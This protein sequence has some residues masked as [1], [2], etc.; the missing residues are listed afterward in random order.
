MIHSLIIN[1]TG[2]GASQSVSGLTDLVIYLLLFPFGRIGPCAVRGLDTPVVQDVF[3]EKRDE[4]SLYLSFKIK[5]P[6]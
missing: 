6:I 1:R 4:R 5:F 3:V 2:T